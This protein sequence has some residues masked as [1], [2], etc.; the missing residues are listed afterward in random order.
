[1]V[2]EDALSSAADHSKSV[3]AAVG[4]VE[5]LHAALELET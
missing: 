5:D 4:K 2:L 1:M 3:V